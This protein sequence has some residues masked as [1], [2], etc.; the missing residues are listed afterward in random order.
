MD[1]SGPQTVAYDTGHGAVSLT[2]VRYNGAILVNKEGERFANELGNSALLGKAITKQTGGVAWLVFDQTAVDHAQLM[3]DYKAKGYF[4]EAATIDELAKKLGIDGQTLAKTV[5]DWHAVYDSKTD[6]AFG[7]KDSIFSRLD[8]APFYGQKISP[9]S[10]TTYGG[11]M[12]DLQ[13]RV[14]RADGTPIPGLYVAGEAASQYGQGVSIG[15]VLGRIAGTEAAKAAL[16][17]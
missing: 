8:H 2:N 6:K 7:R 1:V 5:T 3:A 4:V 9:A 16:G 15:V 14:L 17:K 13:C 10:Q 11:V 12:R